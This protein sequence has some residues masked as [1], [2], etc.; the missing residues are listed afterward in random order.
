MNSGG[1]LSAARA[2]ILVDDEGFAARVDVVVDVFFQHGFGANRT[3]DHGDAD[4][5]TRRSE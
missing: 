5:E 3:V 4:L 2:A 1:F